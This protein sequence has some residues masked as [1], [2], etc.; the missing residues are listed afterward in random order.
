MK[1]FW[2]QNNQ[3]I[4]QY[5]VLYGLPEK[6]L[7]ETMSLMDALVG[8]RQEF[9]GMNGE[10]VE[11]ESF[12][13]HEVDEGNKV[14]MRVFKV[15]KIAPKLVKTITTVKTCLRTDHIAVQF[16][17]VSKVPNT[18]RD[19]MVKS[20]VNSQTDQVRL[21]SVHEFLKLGKANLLARCLQCVP[22]PES[23]YNV[24][25]LPDDLAEDQITKHIITTVINAGAY[26]GP[27]C[28]FTATDNLGPRVHACLQSL[29]ECGVLVEPSNGKFR[30]TDVGFARL[31][32]L[33]LTTK[34]HPVMLPRE[35][36]ALMDRSHWE[37]LV[38]LQDAKW[39]MVPY[40]AR[41]KVPALQL[42]TMKPEDQL[43]YV[44]RKNLDVQ[45]SY[46]EALL[47]I[48]DLIKKGCV[49]LCFCSFRF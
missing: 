38:M 27:C 12:N 47:S 16:L 9:P 13:E 46:L 26:P 20:M 19:L 28:L 4:A 42:K 49:N 36:L 45:H 35:K 43:F 30:M 32:H 7:D 29:K 33:R 25:G 5:G 37:L 41:E 48:P 11:D 22:A 10:V 24:V 23:L 8:E 31:Q 15:L 21:L 17:N 40:K 18:T 1:C 6:S 2:V 14:P 3:E 39:A 34:Y 44:N